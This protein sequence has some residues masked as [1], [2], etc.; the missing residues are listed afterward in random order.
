MLVLVLVVVL[1]TSP[2][3]LGSRK[4]RRT[5]REATS[6]RLSSKRRAF[7]PNGL[8]GSRFGMWQATPRYFA[9]APHPAKECRNGRLPRIT[10]ARCITDGSDS[11]TPRP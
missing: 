3:R 9:S 8:E 4:L 1:P 5:G 2:C 6:C 10:P 11:F 7:S